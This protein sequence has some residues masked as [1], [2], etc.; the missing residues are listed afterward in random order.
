MF[1]RSLSLALAAATALS[2]NV[3]AMAAEYEQFQEQVVEVQT[4]AAVEPQAETVVSY[5][6]VFYVNTQPVED[7]NMTVIDGEVYVAMRAFFNAVLPGSSVNWCDGSAVI[8][9]TTAAGESLLVTARPGD[10]YLVANERYLYVAGGVRNVN[11]CTM[12]P[13]SVLAKIFNAPAYTDSY[14]NWSVWPSGTLLTHGSAYYDQSSLDL[15][16]RLI[17]AE[18]GN[19][20]LSGKIAVGNV[21]MNRVKSAQFPSTIYDVI[22]Q[23]NQFSVVR[24]GTINKTPNESSVLAAKL[25]LDGAE[26]LDDVLF[27][28]QSGLSCWAARNRSYVTTIGSHDFYA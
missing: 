14:G 26:V 16:S 8:T 22:Y 17:Y 19:Q 28:N 9:G 27:F 6:P 25:V 2:L 7:A 1:K 21:I 20:P 5:A 24:N 10:Q 18:S 3:T 11:G 23:K 12:A 15:L 13:I 4:Q